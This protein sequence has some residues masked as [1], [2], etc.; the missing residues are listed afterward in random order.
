MTGRRRAGP[1]QTLGLVATALTLVTVP[2]AGQIREVPEKAASA[3][4]GQK[5]IYVTDDTGTVTEGRLVR[6]GPDAIVLL[7]DGAERRLDLARVRQVDV[8]G[9]SVRNGAII[10]AVIG[11]A[12]ALVSVGLAD[13]PDG[14]SA[15]P[16]ARVIGAVLATGVWA[17][18]GAGIDALIPGRTTLYVAPDVT[19]TP[20]VRGHARWRQG[21]GAG[22]RLTVSW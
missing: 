4:P 14:G 17:A 10:G 18:I 19:R 16:A 15:C 20:V 5:I 2:A 9:D 6:L 12:G 8:R 22:M 13:C 3:A 11:G 1:V 7:S 21:W